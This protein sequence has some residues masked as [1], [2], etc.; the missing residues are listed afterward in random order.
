MNNKFIIPVIAF[1]VLAIFISSCATHNPPTQPYTAP[2]PTPC[3]LENYNY[4]SLSYSTNLPV[5]DYIIT[6][7][8]DY[9]AN[10]AAW[11]PAGSPTPTPVPV[12]FNTK[13]VIGI[14][15]TGGCQSDD[16]GLRN[17]TTDCQ[18]VFINVA[19]TNS[20][21]QGGVQCYAMVAPQ[22]HWYVIDKTYLPI[23]G[24]FSNYD[25]CTGISTTTTGQF[26]PP[27]PTGTPQIWGLRTA[28]PT[29]VM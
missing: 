12:D 2:T 5:W 7:E 29:P 28:T 21:C 19:T 22:T 13:T 8:S 9:L 20:Y 17:I 10:Y 15:V 24:Q 23:V 18:S 4:S 3:A 6:K 26:A 1:I 16:R 27:Y 25:I 14:M 11:A